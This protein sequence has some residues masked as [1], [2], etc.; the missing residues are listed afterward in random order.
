MSNHSSATSQDCGCCWG[1]CDRR[2]VE[3]ERNSSFNQ[4]QLT[5][6][7]FVNFMEIL[8]I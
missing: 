1:V 2:D 6:L 4:L 3:V 8:K 7:I 5:Y